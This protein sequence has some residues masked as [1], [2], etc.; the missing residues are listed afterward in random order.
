MSEL[1]EIKERLTKLETKTEERWNQHDKR[2][3]DNWREVKESLQ[4]SRENIKELFKKFNAFCLASAEKKV[5]CMK[6][7]KEHTEK[8]VAKIVGIWLGIPAS[9]AA[10]IVVITHCRDF[11]TK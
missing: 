8:H 10:I 3:D 6:E 4:E 9:L 1:S 5:Q 2:S 7:A 11:F